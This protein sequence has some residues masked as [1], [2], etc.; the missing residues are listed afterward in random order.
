MK[1]TRPTEWSLHLAIAASAVLAVMV[2]ITLA[3]GISQETFE[4]VRAPEVYAADLRGHAGAVRALF[5]LDSA[6]LIFYA[7]F[8]VVFARRLETS[9]NRTVLRIALGFVLATAVLD[10]IEDH[11]ILS[12]LYGVESGHEPAAGQLWF[13]HLLSQTK[14]HLSYLGLFLFGLCVPRAT[15]G[16]KA[17]A[18]L[19]TVG[20][21][22][23]GAWLYAAPV[24]ALPAGN[25]S[26]WIGFLIGFALAAPLA[27][28]RASDAAATGAPA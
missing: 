13:Q 3:T 17:L 19:L 10:M 11:S 24:S 15:I 1:R 25:L 26:R 5:G 2:A 6:F 21:V 4:I 9:E 28:D 18:L 27:R 12:M 22:A 14:F 23:Q 20:T 7:S 8:F 16:G